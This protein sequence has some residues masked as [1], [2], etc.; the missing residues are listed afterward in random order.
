MGQWLLLQ[1]QPLLLELRHRLR[2]F[3]DADFASPRA[4]ARMRK[5]IELG[6]DPRTNQAVRVQVEGN[7]LTI[8][9]PLALQRIML[10]DLIEPP[11]NAIGGAPRLR[12]VTAT[13]APLCGRLRDALGRTAIDVLV[14]TPPRRA[15]T[16]AQP[17]RHVLG[18][19]AQTAHRF[20]DPGAQFAKLLRQLAPLPVAR[21]HPAL[22]VAA[23]GG[24]ALALHR[25]RRQRHLAQRL[26]A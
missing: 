21:L 17:L 1:L 18:L 25:H 9:P 5:G 2:R 20:R 16:V 8:A 3:G 26:P 24:P 22:F 10:P 11:R 12:G 19:V 23:L 15:Q 13:L 7:L 14:L 6:L 4:L